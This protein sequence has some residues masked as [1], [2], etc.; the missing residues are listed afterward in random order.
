M[1][2]SS[3]LLLSS[4]ERKRHVYVML[5]IFI[6]IDMHTSIKHKYVY[7]LVDAHIIQL[8]GISVTL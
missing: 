8:V 5:H 7:N 4:E 3:Q 2:V 1:T 6:H